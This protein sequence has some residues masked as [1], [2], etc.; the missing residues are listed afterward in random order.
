MIMTLPSN[1]RTGSPPRS[2]VQRLNS[3][4]ARLRRDRRTESLRP[5]PDKAAMPDVCRLSRQLVVPGRA[6]AYH[7]M[8]MSPSQHTARTTC[9]GQ[10]S[11]VPALAISISI[12]I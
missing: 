4:P 7:A 2:L 8:V 5:S 9:L 1:P 6:H 3:L 12:A 10:A 11:H